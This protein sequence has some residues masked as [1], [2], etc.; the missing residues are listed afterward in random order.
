MPLARLAALRA[1]S[2]EHAASPIE[3]NAT[4]Q[5][6][7]TGFCCRVMHS[8]WISDRTS[9][10]IFSMVGFSRGQSSGNVS[11]SSDPN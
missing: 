7:P 11:H 9:V 3:D 4:T 2:R 10:T 5:T 6:A 1:S 8:V